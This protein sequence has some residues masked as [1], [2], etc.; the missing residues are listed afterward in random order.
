MD[1]KNPCVFSYP[2]RTLIHDG[3]LKPLLVLGYCEKSV[4]TRL[5][6]NPAAVS[7]QEQLQKLEAELREVTKNKEK[8][9]RNLLELTEYT[10]MLRVTK[11]F[12]KRNLEV[13]A[14]LGR[15]CISFFFWVAPRGMQ[16]LS[17]LTGDRTRAPC[18]RSTES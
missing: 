17:S 15:E 3:F 4:R 18:S 16:D 2:H 1:C 5:G 6:S 7:F 9:R 8:L 10:H 13:L 12:V 14:T 11:T